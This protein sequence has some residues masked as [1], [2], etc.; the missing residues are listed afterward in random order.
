MAL[1]A[2]KYGPWALVTG[3]S[4]GFG[5]EFC[6]QLADEG[7]NLVLVARR[8]GRL[9]ELAHLLE[10]RC[11]IQTRVIPVDLSTRTFLP[12][13]LRTV[14]DLE[15]GLLVNNAGFGSVRPFLES[16]L[17]REMELLHVNCRAQMALAHEF[18]LKMRERRRGGIIFVSSIAG[19]SYSPPWSNYAA[20]KAYILALAESLWLELKAYHVDVEVL[21]PGRADT[22]FV[23][24]AELNMARANW[25]ARIFLAG[26]LPGGVVSE[27]LKGLGHQRVV[28]PGLNNK[29]TALGVSCLPRGLMMRLAASAM[30]SVQPEG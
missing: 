15:I 19:L 1:L 12:A 28:V 25:L 26:M 17:K 29:L 9:D 13:I 22:E 20:S 7:F 23:S 8:E 2:A 21:C 30:G 4:S 14:D 16:D 24:V 6:S 10:T 18:G 27:S 11:S 5:A 3:A